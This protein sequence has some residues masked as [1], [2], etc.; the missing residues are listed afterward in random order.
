VHLQIHINAANGTNEVHCWL[1][2]VLKSV[3]PAGNQVTVCHHVN[4]RTVCSLAFCAFTAT[5][6]LEPADQA[7]HQKTT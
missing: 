4:R 6:I 3:V 7:V 2:A 1:A 5:L